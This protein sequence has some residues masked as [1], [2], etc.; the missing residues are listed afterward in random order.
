MKKYLIIT[1][2]L[3]FP[4]LLFS[5]SYKIIDAEY[6]I[7]GAGFKFMGKTREYPFKRKFSID[8]K[9]VFESREAL[10]HYL[11]NYVR[12][13]E[14]SRYFDEVKVD[15][16]ARP[17]DTQD[18]YNVILLID[19]Q[20]SHHLLVMPYPKYSSNSG[21]TLKLKAKDTNFFGSLNTMNTELNLKAKKDELKSGFSFSFD[22]LKML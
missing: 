21:L 4:V 8:K 9:T 13:L 12:T 6:D 11:N 18:L 14:S 7:K 20:D 22:D 19:I 17:S 1:L 2:L 5:E 15:Y 10:E 16:E 3:F